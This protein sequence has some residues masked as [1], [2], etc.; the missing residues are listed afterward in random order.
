MRAFVVWP[1]AILGASAR[2]RRAF[3]SFCNKISDALIAKETVGLLVRRTCKNEISKSNGDSLI[4]SGS[5][6]LLKCQAA[7]RA[8]QIRRNFFVKDVIEK[9]HVIWNVTLNGWNTACVLAMCWG[10][11]NL[12]MLKQDTRQRICS[13]CYFHFDHVA[14]FRQPKNHIALHLFAGNSSLP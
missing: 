11:I 13:V 14:C 3:A 7:E 2:T 5:C 10:Q 6:T 9:T 8:L 12:K 4:A 1:H